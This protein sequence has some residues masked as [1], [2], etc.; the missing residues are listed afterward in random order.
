MN[1]LHLT[2]LGVPVAQGSMRH[3]GQGRVVHS[4]QGLEDW[5][6]M[7]AWSAR[8]AMTQAR[9]GGLFAECP[10]G[11][12]VNFWL[13]R[14]KSVP[15]KARR[16]PWVKPDVDKLARAVCDALEGVVYKD[17][18]QVCELLARKFYADW[19]IETPMATIELRIDA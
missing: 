14:P 13:P 16:V 2:V 12:T 6:Q 8:E 15:K 1:H 9:Y 7:V 19:P 4:N 11:I 3:V 10:V 18:G 5:R 17:D